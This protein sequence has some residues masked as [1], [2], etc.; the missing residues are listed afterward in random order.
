MSVDEFSIVFRMM[1][2]ITYDYAQQ[3]HTLVDGIL[4]WILAGRKDGRKEQPRRPR[5]CLFSTGSHGYGTQYDGDR[6]TSKAEF[7]DN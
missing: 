5:K 4:R 7:G 6:M 2:K 1:L 3:E